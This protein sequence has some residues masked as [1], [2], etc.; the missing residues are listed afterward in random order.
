MRTGTGASLELNTSHV[1]V[2]PSP[3]NEWGVYA[4]RD[5]QE[6][7][8]LHEAPGRLLEGEITTV[9]DDV[10]D[11][12]HLREDDDEGELSVLSFGFGALH[13]RSADPRGVN[14]AARWERSERHR[15]N[16]VGTFVALRAVARGEELLLGAREPKTASAAS[17]FFGSAR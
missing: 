13:S 10:F 15:G 14:A 1:F 6:G 11:A 9:G 7:E 2:A 12:S 3:S 8:V 4:A 17:Q 5:F 16:I